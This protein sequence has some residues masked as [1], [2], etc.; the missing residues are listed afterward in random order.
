LFLTLAKAQAGVNHNGEPVH[1]GAPR[2]TY[3]GI[4]VLGDGQ[5]H[6]RN[7]AQFAPGFWRAA[8][9]VEN[10]AGIVL[11]NDLGQ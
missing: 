3:G 1:A 5:H 9:M 11:N 8:H 7:W 10:Q 6:I 2:T 4:Q